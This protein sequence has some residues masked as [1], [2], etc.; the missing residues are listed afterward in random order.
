MLFLIW[1]LT[2]GNNYVFLLTSRFQAETKTMLITN[3]KFCF[4][5]RIISHLDMLYIGMSVKHNMSD[6]FSIFI[7]VFILPYFKDY[8]VFILN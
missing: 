7:T 4:T 3:S 8:N 5:V 1:D 6:V 2:N